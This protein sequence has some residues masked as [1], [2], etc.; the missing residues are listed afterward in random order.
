MSFEVKVPTVGES[1]TE[2]VLLQWFKAE[3]ALVQAEDDLFELETD[4]I[5]LPVKA[6]RAGILHQQIKP[7]EVVQ[8]GQVV[9]QLLPATGREAATAPQETSKASAA[10]QKA[11][12]IAA[13]TKTLAGSGKDAA[14]SSL[15]PRAV[16][17]PTVGESITEGIIL[18]WFYKD[19]ELAQ[20]EKPLFELETDKITLPVMAEISGFLTIQKKAGEV[21]QIGEQVALLSPTVGGSSA[22]APPLVTSTPSIAAQAVQSLTEGTMASPAGRFALAQH[23]LSTQEVKGTGRDGRVMKEDVL[24]H[25]E[26]PKKATSA[27]SPPLTLP[28]PKEASPAPASAS[29]SLDPSGRQRRERMT[30]L[31]KRIAERLVQAQQTAAMLTTFNEV[32]MT[33]AM[34]LR[35]KHQD[36]FAARHGVKL[37]FMSFFVKAVAIA[38]QENPM[39]NAYIDGEDIVYNNFYDIGIAVGTPK[40]LVVPVLRDVEKQG[41]AQIERGIGDLAQKA[42][43]RK[44]TLQ[45]LSGGSFT[46]TNGGVYGSLLSTPILNPPQSGILGMHGIKKRPVAVGDKI[47]IRP[48]MYL[49]LSYDHRIVD[50]KEAVTTLKRIVECVEDPE[51][52][53]LEV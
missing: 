49:A 13:S 22:S 48:M 10:T 16:L 23:G 27:P 4:K 38:L 52:M 25:L 42:R 43:D 51:R 9:A 3:G 26:A 8:I 46:I 12:P 19:G 53:L 17:V 41:F 18:S 7:G 44:L 30:P 14:P 37:G 31:R 45:D 39:M 40:G 1:I 15:P 35:K 6:E 24:R 36:A 50:G 28:L 20:A 2:G 47:E 29:A 11:A 21:V 32:D 5:T 33:R 34:E